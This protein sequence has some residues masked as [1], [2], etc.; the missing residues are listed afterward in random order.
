VKSATSEINF[1][2]ALDYL[3]EKISIFLLHFS[4]RVIKYPIGSTREYRVLTG[5]IPVIYSFAQRDD[6]Q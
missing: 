5:R 3:L 4:G 6:V 2:E 1:D